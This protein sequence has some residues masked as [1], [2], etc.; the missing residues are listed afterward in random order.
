ME[1]IAKTVEKDPLEVRYANMIEDHKKVL[2]PMIEELC[3][4][5]D[6]DIRKRAVDIFNAVRIFNFLL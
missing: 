2:Q 3:Q 6:Y 1:H 5:A 4:N